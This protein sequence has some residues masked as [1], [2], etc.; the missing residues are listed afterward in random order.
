MQKSI[1]SVIIPVYNVEPYLRACMDSIVGQTLQELEIICV[2]DGSTDGSAAILEEYAANDPRIRIIS[3]ENSG[4]SEAR[5]NG[6]RAASGKYIYFMDSDDWLEPD[7]LRILTGMMEQSPVDFIHFRGISF[8][9]TRDSI[10]AAESTNRI[11]YQHELDDEQILSGRDVFQKLI[12]QNTITA[13]AWL[14]LFDRTFFLNNGLWFCPGMLY[15]DQSWFIDVLM[16]AEKVR[17]LNK[18]LYHYRKR[19]DSITSSV[20]TFRHAY[21]WFAASRE[22]VRILGEIQ[23]QPD[24]ALFESLLSQILRMQNSAIS[25]FCRCSPEEKQHMKDLPAD[26]RIVFE[27]EVARPADLMDKKERQIKEIY[28]SETYKIGEA[29]TRIPVK[30]MR[31]L[32]K[33]TSG[34]PQN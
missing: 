19:E 18:V 10:K 34:R 23:P 31:L 26:E 4:L 12:H 3:Q 2:N 13:S 27:K 8:G 5:N 7:T 17:F 9:D 28:S 11:F 20:S 32:R 21:S 15:E 24:P 29:V 25:Q 14:N 6:V 16:H 33:L 30:I 1:V 22:T